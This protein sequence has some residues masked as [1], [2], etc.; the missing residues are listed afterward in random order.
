MNTTRDRRTYIEVDHELIGTLQATVTTTTT[1]TTEMGYGMMFS[2]LSGC[3]FLRIHLS[4]VQEIYDLYNSA[5]L[6][7][8]LN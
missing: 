7:R 5:L 1:T 2:N 6:K 3:V 8:R 4:I